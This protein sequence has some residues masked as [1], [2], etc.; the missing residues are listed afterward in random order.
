MNYYFLLNRYQKSKTMKSNK[1]IFADLSTYTP[2]K[3][4][5]FYE[6]VFGWKYYSDNGYYIA[7][8][9][10]KAIAGLYETPEKFK[11]MR[12]PHFWMTYIQV[13]SVAETVAK[14]KKLGA[15]IEMIDNN[16]PI[17]TVALIRDPQGAGSRGPSEECG[18]PRWT[19][20]L[21]WR[22]RRR[23]HRGFGNGVE[24]GKY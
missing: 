1:I 8:N 22:W 16:S 18:Q 15:I 9:D 5:A 10:N 24:F 11:L 4:I 7:Y 23:S 19:P 21:W 2:N 6:T 3:T 20:G 13:N 12:M 17:G 14:A